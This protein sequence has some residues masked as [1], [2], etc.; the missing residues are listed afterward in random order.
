VPSEPR[1][2]VSAV[3]TQWLLARLPELLEC[4]GK[5]LTPV[6]LLRA[7]STCREWRQHRLLCGP[8]LAWRDAE[9]HQGPATDTHEVEK[10]ESMAE[11]EYVWLEA[12][13]PGG[14]EVEPL[15]ALVKL[16]LKDQGWGNKKGVVMVRVPG[17]SRR[18]NLIVAHAEHHRKKTR[19]WGCLSPS[20]SESRAAEAEQ[21][22]SDGARE[23]S[24]P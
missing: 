13:V 6:E 12:C 8:D 14:G 23:H 24:S 11:R 9:G 10:A 7:N 1:A 2:P 19:L 3:T 16:D 17:A 22:Q 18:E 20:S 4:I 15:A 5:F 21:Q